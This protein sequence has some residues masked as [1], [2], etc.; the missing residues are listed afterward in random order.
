MMI[1]CFRSYAK[2][3]K[4]QTVFHRMNVSGAKPYATAMFST[5]DSVDGRIIIDGSQGEGGGQIVRNVI[6]FANIIRRPIYIHS[7]RAGRPKPRLKEQ[8]LRGMRVATEICGGILRGDRPKPKDV[9]YDPAALNDISDFTKERTITAK[10]QTAGSI[11]LLLQTALPCALFGPTPTKLYV[12]GGTNV[13]MA[14]S[15]D[16]WESVFLPTL[17]DKCGLRPNQIEPTLLKHGYYPRG[18]GVV[19]V[20]VQPIENTL[21]PLT[22]MFR[23]KLKKIHFRAYHSGAFPQQYANRMTREALSILQSRLTCFLHEETI[24]H[25]EAADGDGA[26]ILI[27]ATFECGSRLAG[28]ALAL[29]TKYKAKLVGQ[30][31]AEE[32]YQSYNNGGCVDDWL[33]D[34][35]ILYAAL[36]DGVSEIATG[37][38]T[39][40]TKTA[41]SIAEQMVGAEFEISKIDHLG[42]ATAIVYSPQDYGIDGRIAGKH[43]IRCRGIGFRR[44]APSR[45]T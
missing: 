16:Y 22:L 43:L 8:H 3:G 39:L 29:H 44:I 6:S 13:E 24:E 37:S 15:Y 41:I 35:L 40:H 45:N 27:I 9:Y 2:F 7:I 17:V 5:I 14:P 38:I 26:G 18:G 28:S 34:Q 33:Q 31:A 42:N 4:R 12:T 20:Q 19:E 10:V 30:E 11:S 36:A 23:G 25:R 32:L 1:Y 21:R